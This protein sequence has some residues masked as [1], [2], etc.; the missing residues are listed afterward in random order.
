MGTGTVTFH[1][2]QNVPYERMT[3]WFPME[4]LY[5]PYLREAFGGMAFGPFDDFLARE[6]SIGEFL[7]AAVEWRGKE[8]FSLSRS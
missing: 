6:S 7:L 1:N 8:A 4:K 5:F 3:C 2:E